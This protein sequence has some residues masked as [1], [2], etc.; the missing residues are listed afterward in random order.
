M[1]KGRASEGRNIIRQ[2]NAYRL[3][4]HA[5]CPHRQSVV[6]VLCHST[7][8]HDKDGVYGVAIASM[9]NIV[10]DCRAVSNME[11]P[12]QLRRGCLGASQHQNRIKAVEVG[13]CRG[14]VRRQDGVDTFVP[15]VLF[16]WSHLVA[17][18]QGIVQVCV[19]PSAHSSKDMHAEICRHG[20][21]DSSA[22]T[23]EGEEVDKLL[24]GFIRLSISHL[25]G[26]TCE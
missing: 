8:L 25:P 23:A 18:L 5:T 11:S 7:A 9:V 19:G 10:V 15:V 24:T 13:G 12:Q 14:C 4:T 22:F 17:A 6:D 1:L 20:I 16:S 3:L 26:M 21:T 2:F